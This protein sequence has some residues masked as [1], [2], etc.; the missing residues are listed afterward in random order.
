M[1]IIALSLLLT[2]AA[3]KPPVAQQHVQASVTI[4]AAEEIRFAEMVRPDPRRVVQR[5]S[6]VREGLPMVE[7]Y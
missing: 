2:A 5:Q 4:L 1:S 3:A 6:R 7:F